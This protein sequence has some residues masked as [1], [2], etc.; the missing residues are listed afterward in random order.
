MITEHN[1]MPEPEREDGLLALNEMLLIAKISNDN[2]RTI[3][4]N[5][6]QNVLPENASYMSRQVN[7]R[8]RI[9]RIRRLKIDH[10]DNPKFR[11]GLTISNELSETIDGDMFLWHDDIGDNYD[12]CDCD[13]ILIF[14]TQKN[15]IR[16][17]IS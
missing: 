17:Q 2:P 5:C 16:I 4:K 11:K 7:I 3:M 6:Q 1:H 12:E 8:Q 10:G 15:R 9:N 14:T 13:R